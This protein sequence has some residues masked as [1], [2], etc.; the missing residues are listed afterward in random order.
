M[1]DNLESIKDIISGTT[2]P[3]SIAQLVFNL[4]IGAVIS[5]FLKFHYI[6]YGSTLSN[7][8]EFSNVFPFI[9]LTTT[10]VIAIVK[11]SLAL[12]LGLVGALSIVRFR[13]PIKEPEELAYLFLSIAAGLGLG[14]N[15]TLPTIISIIM[16]LA[17][18]TILKKKNFTNKTKNMFITIERVFANDDEKNKIFDDVNSI[19]SDNV[20]AFDLRRLDY[21]KNSIHITLIVNFK[22]LNSLKQLIIDLD[23]KYSGI[24]INYIDQN[25][26]PSI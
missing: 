13:T 22:N 1:L 23:K 7:R 24:S 15:Q 6:K 26:I 20:E 2:A 17:I 11:S 16:I 9:L 4:I 14:A 25:Q 10:L 3:F 8:N 18:M 5:L 12:S 19:V 21:S